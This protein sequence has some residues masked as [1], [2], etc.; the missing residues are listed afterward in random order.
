MDG[1]LNRASNKLEDAWA[2]LRIIE[3]SQDALSFKAA[4]A[5]LLVACRSIPDAIDRELKPILRA[6]K[7]TPE[8]QKQLSDYAHWCRA[9]L[10][11]QQEPGS[12]LEFVETARDEDVHEGTHR[13]LFPGFTLGS[14]TISSGNG[15]PG[16]SAVVIS[17][18]GPFYIVDANT[19]MQRRVP[20]EGVTMTV[21]VALATPLT[22]HLG[23]PLA[24]TDPIAI[25]KV[26]IG[27]Y[28]DLLWE[29]K[30]RFVGPAAAPT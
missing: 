15:P 17:N 6:G 4:F 30:E 22:H 11:E 25:A 8:G 13:L 1:R 19:P 5:A 24:E 10:R 20:V 18:D 7:K 14:A 23:Q 9:K 2:I 12:L 29:A 26:A 3:A 27:H 16:T 21:T 28:A